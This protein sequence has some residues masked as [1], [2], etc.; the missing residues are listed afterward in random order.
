VNPRKF[1][2]V[3]YK[4]NDPVWFTSLELNDTQH[5]D[6][7]VNLFCREYIKLDESV[8]LGAAYEYMV[9]KNLLLI[10]NKSNVFICIESS[11]SSC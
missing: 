7:S 5:I 8:C 6:E 10:F 11:L 2:F 4:S 1:S 3:H 9:K